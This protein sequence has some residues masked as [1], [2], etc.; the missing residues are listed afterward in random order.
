[1]ATF[2]LLAGMH[3]SADPHWTPTED[4]KKL[5]AEK[6]TELRA[7]TVNYFAGDTVECEYDLVAHLGEQKFQLVSG[8]PK[9]YK[10]TSTLRSKAAPAAQ[11]AAQ[12]APE[13]VVAP[14]PITGTP[15]AVS[16]EQQYGGNF[17]DMRVEE[18]K[19]IADAEE[20][21]LHGARNKAEI[22]E[23]LRAAKK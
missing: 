20:I 10:P 22:I 21:P 11:R 13:G 19:E 15:P 17:D 8:T 12:R 18:L 3:Q 5:A 14:A 4:E 7:P 9:P 1:M 2:R 16:L 23:R 6:K